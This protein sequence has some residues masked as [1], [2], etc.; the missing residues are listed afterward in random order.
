LVTERVQELLP[1]AF[2]KSWERMPAGERAGHLRGALQR[3]ELRAKEVAITLA[4]GPLDPQAVEMERNGLL[5]DQLFESGDS[6][7]LRLPIRLKTWGGEKLIHVPGGGSPGNGGR[8]DK[9]LLKAV[10]RAFAWRE[11][12]ESEE[13][14]SISDLVRKV[15]FTEDY[16]RR[17]LKLAFLSPDIVEAILQGRQPLGVTLSHILQVDLPLSWRIQQEVL[18]FFTESS[19]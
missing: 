18:G 10:A 5:G 12:L 14:R 15:G 17:I 9:A 7:I 1:A 11:M 6:L 16:V 2:R 13:A 19:A 8:P 4:K 3:V